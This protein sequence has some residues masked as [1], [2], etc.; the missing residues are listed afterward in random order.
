[1]KVLDEPCGYILCNK[2]ATKT[3]KA[4]EYVNYCFCDEHYEQFH[5]KIEESF[6]SGIFSNKREGLR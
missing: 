2:T 4:S 6:Q 1:M 3:V 5:K